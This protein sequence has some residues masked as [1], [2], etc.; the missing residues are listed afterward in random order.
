MAD[1]ISVRILKTVRTSETFLEK[2]SN[3]YL[4][5]SLPIPAPSL[6]PY[7]LAAFVRNY[8]A[9]REIVI[10]VVYE[11]GIP[12][13]L[14]PL[15]IKKANCL[16]F[17]CDETS[18]YNDFILSEPKIELLRHALKYW[19]SKGISRYYLKNLHP[20]S[21]T[22]SLLTQVTKEFE[23]TIDIKQGESVPIIIP[24]SA[25][26]IQKWNGVRHHHVERYIRKLHSLSRSSRVSFQFVE[27][28]SQLTKEFSAIKSMHI[29]RWRHNNIVSKYSDR[30]RALFVL[31]ICEA[32][33]EEDALFLPIMKIDDTLAAFIIGFKYGNTV[34]DWNTSFS[35][36]FHKWSP[37]ALLLLHVLSNF[38]TLQFS[39]YN[40]M[41]GN[42]IYKFI[43]TDK[44]EH[45][46]NVSITAK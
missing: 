39:K 8:G 31:E 20:N 33:I 24:Q 44:V 12:K 37:G 28:K 45:N 9:N 32:A 29:S 36:D 11:N 15:Q 6:Q 30:R 13:L 42:E 25:L 5:K 4:L 3:Q 34:F 27:T 7:W 2:F 18:D 43:W 1:R 23:W 10:T 38:E 26:P 35:L 17:V 19:N 22:L 16:E 14:M 46:L 40:L 21:P 41:K